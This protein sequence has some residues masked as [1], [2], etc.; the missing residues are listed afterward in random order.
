[1]KTYAVGKRASRS[2]ASRPSASPAIRLRS[3]AATPAAA[4]ETSTPATTVERVTAATP[5]TTSG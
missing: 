5:W 4:S 3:T 1:V 2:T